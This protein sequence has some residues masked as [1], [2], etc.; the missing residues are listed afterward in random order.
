[1]FHLRS[2]ERVVC[3]DRP[4]VDERA[5]SAVPDDLVAGW[6][7]IVGWS[8]AGDRAMSELAGR[9]AEPHRRYHG[10]EHLVQVVRRV[11][12]L[13]PAE[14]DH[15]LRVGIDAIVLAAW[16][17]DAVYDPRADDNERRSADLGD[18]VLRMLGLPEHTLAAVDR[19]VMAT[20]DHRPSSLDEAILLDAD[21]AVLGAASDVY[22]TYVRH[23]R[24][25]FAHVSD[26][27]WRVGRAPVLRHLLSAP[28]FVTATAAHA[29]DQ[30][31]E[32]LGAELIGL[33]PGRTAM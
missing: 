19:L 29:N 7:A 17:H 20:R 1:M 23:V 26:D 18:T 25:E 8:D 12:E 27:D 14:Y 15:P 10:V 3:D 21:L 22:A 33:G 6:R 11:N 5:A 2:E 16:F 4:V 32:N 30:A 28:I 9:Y 24:A 31:V 13:L